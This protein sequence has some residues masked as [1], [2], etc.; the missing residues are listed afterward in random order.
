MNPIVSKR[1]TYC[2]QRNPQIVDGEGLPDRAALAAPLKRR[3]C[4]RLQPPAVH[5][6]PEQT[7]AR[8]IAQE[9]LDGMHPSALVA[10]PYIARKPRMPTPQGSATGARRYASD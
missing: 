6:N 1:T 2:F 5:S 3:L 9:I 8:S 7:C 4:H 10:T